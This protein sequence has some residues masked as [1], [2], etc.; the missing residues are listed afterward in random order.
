M[1]TLSFI[2]AKPNLVMPR[3]SPLEMREK[4]VVITADVHKSEKPN[5]Y[6][7]HL[8]GHEIC[9]EHDM[10]SVDTHP[11][12]HHSVLNLIDDCGPGG[13]NSQSPLNL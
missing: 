1:R 11:V 8:V 2:L 10:T 6:R 7:S 9:Q 13:L 5:F 4:S 3:I 12:V